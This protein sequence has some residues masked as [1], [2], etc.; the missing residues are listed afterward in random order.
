MLVTTGLILLIA[1]ANIDN[2]FSI[3]LPMLLVPIIFTIGGI[4]LILVGLFEPG[5]KVEKW[6][7]I[8]DNGDMFILVIMA[9]AYPVH[10]IIVKFYEK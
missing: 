4:A 1:I 3:E 2:C 6:S 9:L 5:E 7:G 8:F 10:L